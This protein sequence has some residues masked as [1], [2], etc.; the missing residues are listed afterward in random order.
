MNAFLALGIFTVLLVS[1]CVFAT[2]QNRVGVI[3]RGHLHF[4]IGT[5]GSSFLAVVAAVLAS[6]AACDFASVGTELILLLPIWIA[7]WLPYT[8]LFNPQAEVYGCGRSEHLGVFTDNTAESSPLRSRARRS[9]TNLCIASSL[10]WLFIV[11][12]FFAVMKT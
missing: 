10:L 9:I 4:L 8:S 12:A 1:A 7:S 6:K 5:Y 2:E 3:S 11:F